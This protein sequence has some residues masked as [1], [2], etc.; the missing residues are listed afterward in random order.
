MELE[1]GRWAYIQLV[2]R[3][4]ITTDGLPRASMVR[5]LPGVYASPVADEK[6]E[7]L[8]IR[9]AAFFSQVSLGGMLDHGRVRGHWQPPER[10]SAVPERRMWTAPDVDN[11]DGWLVITSDN[12]LLTQRQYSENHP[13]VDQR[14][15]P[16]D[17]IPVPNRLRWLIQVGWTPRQARSRRD[18][19]W[20]DDDHPS[21][22]PTEP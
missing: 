4:Y 16:L 11:P 13:E 1:N 2:G 9:D 14:M 12:Q 15:L 18:D 19:W 22:P 10:E 17:T 20:S 8:V 3:T 5:V 6:I 7:D 21:L